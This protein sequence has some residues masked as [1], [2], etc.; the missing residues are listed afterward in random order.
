MLYHGIDLVCTVTVDVESSDRLHVYVQYAVRQVDA[1][2][3]FQS[4]GDDF[5]HCSYI[6]NYV[7]LPE[8]LI[9]VFHHLSQITIKYLTYLKPPRLRNIPNCKDT[10][11]GVH[12]V[13]REPRIDMYYLAEEDE[14]RNETNIR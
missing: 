6:V 14:E 7:V 4:I 8:N 2:F 13:K 11:H 12:V 1:C 5:E 10:K 9:G 3:T